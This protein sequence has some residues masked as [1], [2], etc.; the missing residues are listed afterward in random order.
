MI[1]AFGASDR[2]MK[3]FLERVNTNITFYWYLW[4]VNRWLSIRFALLSAIVVGLTGYVLVSSNGKLHFFSLRQ[5]FVTQ[6]DM[7]DP[8]DAALA[9]FALSFSLNISTEILF[10][11]RR[12]TAL[13]LT[14][15]A[16]ERLKEYSELKQEAAEIVYPRPEATWPSKGRIQV[17]DLSIRFVHSKAHP[18]RQ[19]ESYRDERLKI[20]IR[21]IVA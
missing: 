14:L 5:I 4:S 21:S 6:S 15:V 1:R 18:L 8:V 7:H 12:Y 16:V 2:F 11:V 9:G 17:K 13:E 10:L 20:Q 3:L 19:S